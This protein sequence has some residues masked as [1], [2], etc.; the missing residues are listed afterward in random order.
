MQDRLNWRVG[1]EE[2]KALE[3]QA[4][5]LGVE[6]AATYALNPLKLFVIS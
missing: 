6:I 2:G 1:L 5:N 3:P 4:L